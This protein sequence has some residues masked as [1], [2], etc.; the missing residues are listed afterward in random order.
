MSFKSVEEAVLSITQDYFGESAT[1]T[2]GAETAEIKAVFDYQWVELNGVSSN[3]L[4][5]KVLLA[6]LPSAP[7]KGDTIE[8]TDTNETFRVTIAQPDGLGGFTL[9]LAE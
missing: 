2:Q 8:R 6:D 4:T 9:V 3:E 5:A 1:Y 7:Q